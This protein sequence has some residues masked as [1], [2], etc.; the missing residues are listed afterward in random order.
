[1]SAACAKKR[2]KAIPFGKVVGSILNLK[3][4]RNLDLYMTDTTLVAMKDPLQIF[5]HLSPTAGV[6]LW[7]STVNY[8]LLPLTS[9]KPLIECNMQVS[10]MANL[11]ATYRKLSVMRRMLNIHIWFASS[12]TPNFTRSRSPR[13][14]PPEKH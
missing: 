2:H 5:S 3:I 14:F 6:H 13:M 4:L 11:S 8:T 10:S 1:M 7:S 9:Q 12:F